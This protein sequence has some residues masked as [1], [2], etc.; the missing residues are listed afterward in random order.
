MKRFTFLASLIAIAFS[1]QA[2]TTIDLTTAGNSF[3][4]TAAI[5]GS[6]TVTQTSTSSTGTGVIDSFLRVQAKGQERG[7]NTDVTP[8]PLDDKAGNFTRVLG[9]SEIP[10]VTIGGVVYRQF[11]LD[12]NQSNPFLLSLNQIQIF[13]SVTDPTSFTLTEATATT[14]AIISGLGT[15]V[16]QMSNPSFASASA[17][18]IQMDSS[19]NAGSGSGDMFLYVKDSDF[20]AGIQDV[21]LF[22]QFGAPPGAYSSN[23]GFEEWAVLKS[24]GSTCVG[25]C[26]SN[27][28]EP[29]SILLLGTLLLGV[30]QIFRKRVS[31][32]RS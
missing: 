7:Y 29:T 10:T 13:Q 25:D 15:Q 26:T 31:A 14:E 32:T 19:L 28:P 4:Q 22:S 8:P 2:A 23:G 16:F 20:V 30:S 3:T 6:F 18:Q 11:L 24:A 17:Y 1:L 12:I 21:V 5:G 27:V 9:L